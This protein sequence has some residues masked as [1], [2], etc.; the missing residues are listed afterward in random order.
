[1]SP[2]I[3]I[4]SE[5]EVA[6]A[7]GDAAKRL[8]ILH[9]VTDLF[10]LQA[11]E[12]DDAGADLF[13]DVICRLSRRIEARA[14]AE[15]AERLADVRNAPVRVIRD[16]AQDEEIAMARPVVERSPRLT[17]S[18]LVEIA[19]RK[20]QDH[21]LALSRRS[22]LSASVTDILLDRGNER[23]VRS[24]AGNDGACFSQRG[25]AH[26]VER[27]RS[28]SQL[29]GIL[30]ARADIPPDHLRTL[31]TIA[32][33]QVRE[34]LTAEI[35]PVPAPVVEATLNQAAQ[36]VEQ[37]PRGCIAPEDLK[38]AEQRVA[39]YARSGTLTEG[40]VLEWI[41][42]GDLDCGLAGM[43][44]LANLSVGSVTNGLHA[45]HH[46]SLLFIVRS[47]QFGWGTLK[48]VLTHKTGRQPPPDVARSAFESFQQLSVAT[49]QRVVRFTALREH[50]AKPDD[51]SQ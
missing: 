46:D 48:L 11:S 1:M 21:L 13:D 12:L 50:A 10:L 39:Y 5:V 28:D 38:G 20:G 18:D 22:V 44:H 33:E 41:K 43:A 14:R 32:R 37:D 19:E 25:Y 31:V 4:I 15:L 40:Q 26:L 23:V 27:A 17:E 24:T 49:A 29:Q 47:L 36:E 16:L 6:L 30:Q 35:G 2:S 7:R 42:G 34:R 51:A 9:R 3:S 45:P 8:A